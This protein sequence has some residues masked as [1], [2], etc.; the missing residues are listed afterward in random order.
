V[1]DY[2]QSSWVKPF[3]LREELSDKYGS[4]TL[5]TS[6]PAMHRRSAICNRMECNPPTNRI[7][8]GNEIWI[9]AEVFIAIIFSIELCM[10]IAVAD[11]VLRYF[12]DIMNTFDILAIL[13]FYVDLHAGRSLDFSIVPSSPQNYLIVI[14]RSFKVTFDYS[15]VWIGCAPFE[16]STG[17]SN[18]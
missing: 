16:F 13:P 11:S 9:K 18:V 4:P 14:S 5:F 1:D 2:G 12:K 6:R 10:R 3:Q 7:I 8:D 17:F 15:L